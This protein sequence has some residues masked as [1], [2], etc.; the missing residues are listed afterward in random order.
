MRGPVPVEQLVDLEALSEGG[1]PPSASRIRAALPRGWVL[2]EDG[3]TARRDGR[4]FFSQGW[5]LI[6]G[7]IAFGAAAIGLFYRTFPRG[8]SG[9][10][11]ALGLLVLLLVLGGLVAPAVTRALNRRGWRK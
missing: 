1:R 6:A 9:V 7:L 10:G 8:W 4:L 11:R 2:D 5:V 3:R